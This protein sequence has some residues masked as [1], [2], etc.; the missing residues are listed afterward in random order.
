MNQDDPVFRISIDQICIGLYIHLDLSWMNHPFAFGDFK[1]ADA[2]QIA[3]IKTLGLKTL[4]YDPNRSDVSPLPLPKAASTSEAPT[5]E[6]EEIN[7]PLEAANHIPSPS[8]EFHL[9]REKL[10]RKGIAE[11][12]VAFQKAYATARKIELE[13]TSRPLLATESANQFVNAMVDSVLSASDIMLHALPSADNVTRR[14]NHPI[15]V[16]VLSLILARSMN[17]SADEVRFLALGSLFHD[18]GKT[19]IPDRITQ[20]PGEHTAAETALLRQHSNYS[21]TIVKELKLPK[22]V[23][24]IVAQHHEFKDGTGYPK[25]LKGDEIYKLA[26]ITA[27]VNLYDNLCN[28]INPQN[29]MSPYEAL[30][31][32][33]AK[34]R[35]KFDAAILQI[36][37]KNLGVYPPGSI[38]QLSDRSYGIVASVNPKNALRPVIIV[39]KGNSEAE[40]KEIIDLAEHDGLSITMC[41]NQEK[42]PASTLKTLSPSKSLSYY[43]QAVD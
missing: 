21:E 3:Q 39:D 18:I 26:R 19:K 25:K 37:I 13:V 23:A 4:R 17:I 11:C 34:Q 40:K 20:N 24:L 12:E 30:A 42:I 8:A 5:I 10:L 36:L 14:Y 35:S 28:P 29:R 41:L 27:V 31:H 43:F 2:A 16:T 7:P 33:F 38:V 6:V 1:I 22:E 32:L 15:N 9:E